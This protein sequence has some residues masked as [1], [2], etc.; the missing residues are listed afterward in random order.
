MSTPTTPCTC[1]CT[2]GATPRITQLT[3]AIADEAAYA[4]ALD[5]TIDSAREIIARQHDVLTHPVPVT[6]G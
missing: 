3:A 4:E 6:H 2:C 1:L 5:V